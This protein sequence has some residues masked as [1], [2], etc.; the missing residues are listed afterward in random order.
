LATFETFYQLY[1]KK[2]Q[3][4]REVH[5]RITRHEFDEMIARG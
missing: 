4:F 1:K 3:P 2:E 5:E